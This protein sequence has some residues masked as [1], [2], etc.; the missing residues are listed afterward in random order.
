MR[1]SVVR[2]LT[3]GSAATVMLGLFGSP[4]PARALPTLHLYPDSVSPCNTTLQACI[5]GVNGGDTIRIVTD[6]PINE[7]ISIDKSLVLIAGQGF[8]P[9]ITGEQLHNADVA[10]V[11]DHSGGAV[12]VTISGIHFTS[13]AVGVLFDQHQGDSFTLQG[14]TVRHRID[15]NNSRG[16]DL[17]L[18]TSM[19]VVP[20]EGN[21]FETTG[22][23]VHVGT[24]M[25]NAGDGARIDVI[26]NTITTSKSLNAGAGIS[27][28][29]GGAG[30]ITVNAESNAVHH[31]LGCRCGNL[32][33]VDTTV[34]GT[35]HATVNLVGNTIDRT[36]RALSGIAIEPSSGIPT[37][38]ENIFDN[39]VTRSSGPGIWLPGGPDPATGITVNNGDNDFFH[40]GLAPGQPSDHFGGYSQGP[41]TVSLDPHYVDPSNANY[42]LRSTS[43]LRDLGQACTVGG[44]VR[45]DAGNRF[46][47]SGWNVDMGAYEFGAGPV[48]DGENDFGTNGN[49]TFAGT[50]GADVICG[51]RGND[52]PSPGDGNDHIF[53]GPGDEIATGGAG[54][55]WILAGPGADVIRGGLG[56]DHLDARDGKPGDAVTGGGGRDVC[57]ADQGDGVTGCEVVRRS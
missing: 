52:M 46:R 41:R 40:N 38:T 8:D 19:T 18:R 50:A 25:A 20:I 24:D 37:L 13:G 16:V 35:V 49:D 21:D 33:S 4:S 9:A 12:D 17:D 28:D 45:R 3:A 30:T 47:I 22:M 39:L 26:G 27:L 42:R 14:S 5:D 56:D 6:G 1:R 48:P 7:S 54:N 32:G 44:L 51:F 36:E 10:T 31:M 57:F 34:F 55:D 11:N 15:N 29:L 2:V 43:P 53:G 23:P